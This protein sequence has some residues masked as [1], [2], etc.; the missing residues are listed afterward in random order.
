[1]PPLPIRRRGD[2]LLSVIVLAANRPPTANAPAL[3]VAEDQSSL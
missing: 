3:T 2:E 1:L